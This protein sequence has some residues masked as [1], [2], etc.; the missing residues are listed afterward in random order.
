MGHGLEGRSQS[1]SDREK[2]FVRPMTA[3]PC[4]LGRSGVRSSIN[5]KAKKMNITIVQLLVFASLLTLLAVNN[6]KYW[7]CLSGWR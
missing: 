1:L 7:C 6:P 5:K 3:S 4:A 2:A